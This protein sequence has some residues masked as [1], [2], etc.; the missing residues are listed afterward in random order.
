MLWLLAQA[1][2]KITRPRYLQQRPGVVLP[3]MTTG[4]VDFARAGHSVS[5]L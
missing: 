3:A 5:R 2:S 1:V 4:R